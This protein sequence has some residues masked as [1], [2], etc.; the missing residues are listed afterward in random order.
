MARQLQL[1]GKEY[2]LATACVGGGQGYAIIL[3]RA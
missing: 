3:Q 1:T 2:G